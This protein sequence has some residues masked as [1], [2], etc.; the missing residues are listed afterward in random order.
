MAKMRKGDINPALLDSA[1][2]QHLA[3][4]AV[5]LGEFQTVGVVGVRANR[6]LV[7]PLTDEYVGPTFVTGPVTVVAGEDI[8]LYQWKV[9]PEGTPTTC[10]ARTVGYAI[11]GGVML[12]PPMVA[13]PVV[14]VEPVVKKPRAAAA[15]SKDV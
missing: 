6:L 7:A 4:A 8:E 2:V 5:P 13:E 12:V 1:G 14:K 15:E 3:F 9:A 10:G 11:Q